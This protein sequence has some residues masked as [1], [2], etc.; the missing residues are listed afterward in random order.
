MKALE[1]YSVLFTFVSL[2]VSDTYFNESFHH[3]NQKH[4]PVCSVALIM[5]N[6][7]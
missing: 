1:K 5:S 6:T 7:L 2:K 4:V 3:M